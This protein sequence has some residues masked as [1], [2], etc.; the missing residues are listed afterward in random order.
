MRKIAMLVLMA[1]GLGGL[2]FGLRTVAI[3]NA[4]AQRRTITGQRK[5]LLFGS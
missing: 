2:S 5:K 1:L 3:S 4:Q